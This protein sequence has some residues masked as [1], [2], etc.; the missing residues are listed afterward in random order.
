MKTLTL[1]RHAK[2]DWGSPRLADHDRPLN[3]RGMADAPMMAQRLATRWAASRLTLP[4]LISSTALRAKT[5]AN[6]VARALNVPLQL[7]EALYPFALHEVRRAISAV[8][9]GVE[10]V[11]L[12]GHNPGISILAS[13]LGAP[14]ALELPTAAAVSLQFEANTWAEVLAQIALTSWLDKPKVT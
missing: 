11:M 2:S 6:F 3:E 10:H 5:T 14:A 4:L 8:G 12:V 13:A 7:E 1:M 9:D